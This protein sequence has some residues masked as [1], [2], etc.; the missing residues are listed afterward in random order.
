MHHPPFRP[1]IEQQDPA[2]K[3]LGYWRGYVWGPMAQL[4]YW[5]LQNYGHVPSAATARTAL[6]KQMNTMMLEQWRNHGYICGASA[7]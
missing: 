6:C 2:F 4:T 1:S 5:G 7:S 3:A